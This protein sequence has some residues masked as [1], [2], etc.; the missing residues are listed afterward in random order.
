M[1][2][3]RRGYSSDS[4]RYYDWLDRA[5]EDMCCARLLV[6]D[7]DCYNGCAF[8]CQQAIEKALKAYLLLKSD[9]LVDGHNL[10]WLCKQAMRYDK[11]FSDWLDESFSLNKCYIE[12]RYPA[13][14]P[15]DFTTD[16]I[17]AFLKMAEDMYDFINNEVEQHLLNG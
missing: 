13:D 9:R 7:E 16:K 2:R 11:R 10:T 12:T 14:I 1:A 5:D 6:Q 4:R 17:R 15:S 8:H 3:R